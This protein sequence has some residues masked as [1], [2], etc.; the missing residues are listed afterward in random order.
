M[1]PNRLP[2]VF[3]LI[4]QLPWRQETPTWNVAWGFDGLYQLY[5]PTRE[6]SDIIDPTEPRMR[7]G[8]SK[9]RRQGA[10]PTWGLSVLADSD[11]RTVG[12]RLER[13]VRE[14]ALAAHRPG[15]MSSG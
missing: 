4:R 9:G 6:G 13:E 2:E 8:K 15:R 7:R 11:P 5:G 12:A 10:P 1:D 14:E 3:N